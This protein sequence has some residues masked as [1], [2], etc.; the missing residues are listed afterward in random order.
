M[1]TGKQI[2]EKRRNTLLPFKILQ[3]KSSNV[4]PPLY[5]TSYIVFASMH[6]P[7]FLV[8]ICTEPFVARTELTLP[9]KHFCLKMQCTSPCNKVLV[10]NANV[11]HSS[12]IFTVLQQLKNILHLNAGHDFCLSA[13]RIKPKTAS[14]ILFYLDI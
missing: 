5:A 1:Q 11:C 2:F 9:E 3:R 8:G 13:S 10:R 7:L 6:P 4:P 14:Q 12:K